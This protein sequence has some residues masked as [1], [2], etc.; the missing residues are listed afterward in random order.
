MPS[1][2]YILLLVVNTDYYPL[3][4]VSNDSVHASLAPIAQELTCRQSESET[5]SS[6]LGKELAGLKTNSHESGRI[7]CAKSEKRKK[8]SSQRAPE[9]IEHIAV[10]ALGGKP[11]SMELRGFVSDISPSQERWP[12]AT[13]YKR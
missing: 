5:I 4:T 6:R 3:S 9:L 10:S 13:T 7:N 1:K 11:A 2:P 8:K 12:T